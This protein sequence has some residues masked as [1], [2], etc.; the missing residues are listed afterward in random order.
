MRNE[1]QRFSLRKL[2]IGL[3][4][5]LIGI[6]F[7]QAGQT[8]HA[9]TVNDSNS[10]QESAQVVHDNTT[11]AKQNANT[12][13]TMTQNSEIKADA[14]VAT[15]VKAKADT[16]TNTDTQSDTQLGENSAKTVSTQVPD[17]TQDKQVVNQSAK[18]VV[19][20]IALFQAAPSNQNAGA[21]RTATTTLDLNEKAPA[22]TANELSESKVSTNDLP[23]FGSRS[24]DERATGTKH[25]RIGDTRLSDDQ[26]KHIAISSDIKITPQDHTDKPY[27]DGDIGHFKL[28]ECVS[29]GLT[30]SA[31][32]DKNDLKKDTNIL[33]GTIQQSNDRY[34]QDY[35][36]FGPEHIMSGDTSNIGYDPQ[37]DPHTPEIANGSYFFASPV[38]FKDQ[39]IGT[40]GI[41]NLHDTNEYDVYLHVNNDYNFATNPEITFNQRFFVSVENENGNQ[42]STVFK[43]MKPDDKLTVQFDTG[44]HKYQLDYSYIK[45]DDT[46][47]SSVHSDYGTGLVWNSTAREV[48]L[49]NNLKSHFFN[50][51]SNG[52]F[53]PANINLKNDGEYDEAIKITADSG[54]PIT[55]VVTVARGTAFTM[56]ANDQAY[57]SI[58]G[59]WTDKNLPT[60]WKSDGLSAKDLLDQTIP[61]TSSLSRQSDGSVIVAIKATKDNFIG[62][63]DGRDVSNNWA[64]N[65]VDPE[66]ADQIIQ[67]TQ[68]HLHVPNANWELHIAIGTDNKKPVMIT[69]NDVTPRNYSQYVGS[70]MGTVTGISGNNTGG[71]NAETYRFGKVSYVDDDKNGIEIS[72]DSIQGIR[73]KPTDYTVSIP[74]GFQLA[75]SNTDS[76]NYKWSVDKKKITYTFKDDQKANDADPIVIHLKHIIQPTNASEN[77]SAKLKTVRTRTIYYV[78]DDGSLVKSDDVQTVTFTRTADEDMATH[79]LSN[80]GEWT[81]DGDYSQI[82]VPVVHGYTPTQNVVPEQTANPDH[83][84]VLTVTYNRN[85]QQIKVAYVDDT[86]G[87]TLD[88][89]TL[90]GYSKDDSHY[91]TKETIDDYESH[92]YELVSDGTPK[93]NPTLH[94]DSDDFVNNQDYTVHLK[95]TTHDNN[96]EHSVT[97][98]IHYVYANGTKAKD[99]DSLTLKFTGKETIDNVTGKTISTVWTP[100]SQ[101]FS[102]VASPIIQGYTADQTLIGD[103]AVNPTSDNIVKTVTYNPN[104]QNIHVTFIDDTT[105]NTLATIA[106]S[107]YTNTDSGYSTKNDID[108]LI[109]K[110]YKLVN[111]GTPK[112]H[113]TLMFDSDDFTDDQNFMVHME[114][115]TK[116]NNLSREVSRTI[117]YVYRDGKPAGQDKTD[118][119]EFNGVEKIDKVD[120]HVISTIWT[121]ENKEFASVT[122]PALQGYT[123]DKFSVDSVVVKPDSDNQT[124]T[125]TYNPN[126]QYSKFNYI[127]DTTGNTLRQESSHGVTSARD[128]YSTANLISYYKN[129]GYDLVSDDTANKVLTFDSDDNTDQIYNIHFTHGIIIIDPQHKGKPG[130]K[131]NPQD[132]S[133]PVYPKGSDNLTR[134][135]DREID[136]IYSDGHTAK[137]SVKDSITFNNTQKIDRVTGKIISSTWDGPKDFSV[138]QTPVI[139]GYT[140]SQTSVENKGI[141]HDTAPIK[142]VVTYSADP[143][144]M[145]VIYRDLTDNRILSQMNKDGVSD[146]NGHYNTKSAIDGY[147]ANGYVLSSDDT[148][149][150]DLIFDHNDKLDQTYYVDFTHGSHQYNP[151]KPDAKDKVDKTDYLADY[152]TTINY[153]DHSGKTLASNKVVQDEYK[154]DLTIDSVNGNIIKRGDWKLK[155]GYI[156]VENPVITG[157]IT[158]NKSVK[159]ADMQKNQTINVVYNV[160]GKVHSVDNNGKEIAKD[161]AYTNDPADPTKVLITKVPSVTGYEQVTT[162]VDP[163]KDPLHDTTVVFNAPA[164]VTVNYVDTSTGKTIHTDTVKGF[165]T[166]TSDYST[167]NE[168]STLVKQG[169]VLTK[170]NVP[171]NIKLTENPQNYVVT[172][173]HGI[174]TVKHDNPIKGGTTIPNTDQK[175][176]NGVDTGDL[177]REIVRTITIVDPHTGNK[178]TKQTVKL[179]RDA[180]VDNVTG[181]VTYTNWNKGAWDEFT[182][183][184]VAGYTP[185][186]NNV[187]NVVVTSNTKPVNVVITYTANPQ[188]GKISYVDEVGHEVANTPL[189]GKTDETIAIT[190]QIPHGWVIVDGQTIPTSVVARPDGIPTVLIK[191]KHGTIEVMPDKPHNPTDKMPDGDQYP[192]GVTDSDLNREITR[193]INIVDPHT[194]LHTTV[195]TAHLTRNATIDLVTK[196][197]TYGKWNRSNWGE[198]DVPMVKGYTPSASKVA[199]SLVDISTKPTTVNITY[200]ANPQKGKISY[201]DEGGHEVV[202]TPLN[203]K[204]DEDVKVVPS[205]PHGWVLDGKQTI[206][207]TVKATADGI[208]TVTIKIKHGTLQ[209]TPDK[210]HKDTDKMPDGD[211]YPKGVDDTDLNRNFTRQI[212][213]HEPSGDKTVNQV[214]KYTR[215][216]TIDLV[217]GKVTYTDWATKHG[218][219]EYVPETVNG[220]MPSIKKLAK[221]DKPDKDTKVE[222]NYTAI[223]N[224]DDNWNGTPVTPNNNKPVQSTE[225][226]PNKPSEK[227]ASKKI[228]KSNKKKIRKNRK[229]TGKQLGKQ[230]DQKRARNVKRS[231]FLRNIANNGVANENSG[232]STIQDSNFNRKTSDNSSI[233]VNTSSAVINTPNSKANN[234]T[235]NGNQLPQTGNENDKTITLAGI[236]L[237][238]MG[239]ATVIGV[240]RKKRN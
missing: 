95:H 240:S 74:S 12:V 213:L 135:V 103:I 132:P 192:D 67:N 73:N 89:K 148:N 208:P 45:F 11:K 234:A 149:G 206:P 84:V 62:M 26:L 223:P 122:T 160:L 217:T 207:D 1:K 201:V 101:N 226:E 82:N 220:Y 7:T 236:L 224:S 229:Q 128:N 87:I 203:G 22:L 156:S 141:K 108:S 54:N 58:G 69:A 110:G 204:T 237:A 34:G 186:Q 107:G 151:E 33:I 60:N 42:N 147:V 13:Q 193:T 23:A 230:V 183:P 18:K 116:E 137:P 210:P 104:K 198:F 168:I 29:L 97:R 24:L 43:G 127:D 133:S 25:T 190:P 196:A 154:R 163:T 66:H 55:G 167:K 80:F 129:K 155:T 117:H 176:P 57:K 158:N 68:K 90:D 50:L 173:V 139:E 187:P 63:L 118:S 175:M 75:A 15:Q 199:K 106:K 37:H 172:L 194:G 162:S 94:F 8:V 142:V 188:T 70:D 56:N 38:T 171:A 202:N 140:P 20:N 216:A 64:T 178:V 191:I 77:S 81:A 112:D 170:D 52:N 102:E 157:Y 227:P 182:T 130:E 72:K 146:E 40:V 184:V 9:D 85:H 225:P 231:S 79:E 174:T 228:Q 16:Q 126:M 10:A 27:N 21:I 152:T 195:Q 76:T 92:G 238:S 138:I 59:I 232:N 71:F 136:Y 125:V 197:I 235:H 105:G 53:D 166:H 96:L 143:Q 28:T 100:E 93:D 124:I 14:K 111:D 209:V 44:Q 211:N 46:T 164:T 78:Y 200:T 30:G 41:S 212:I 91:S 99:D 3:A 218:W 51:D 35:T 2:S 115:D 32:L 119:I 222:I 219:D 83:N 145:T 181:A 144:H 19:T 177:N 98:T 153:V 6:A 86:T 169:Y 49:L 131:L 88:T 179:F 17:Q 48:Y 134:N 114:H 221:V 239:I 205:L 4:S 123:P 65:V 161:F 36:N 233:K 214:A 31:T 5:V 39:E 189:N 215:V 165:A 120:G 121:P 113:P 185:S 180:T 159:P 61:G 47:I 150:K 109:A